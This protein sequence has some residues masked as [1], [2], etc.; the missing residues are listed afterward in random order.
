MHCGKGKL[1][2]R[3]WACWCCGG[4]FSGGEVSRHRYKTNAVHDIQ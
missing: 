3:A 1:V 4:V 2:P